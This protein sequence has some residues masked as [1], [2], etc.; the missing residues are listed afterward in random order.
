ME[1]KLWLFTKSP[2]ILILSFFQ[3]H[4]T[5]KTQ[6][7]Q[8]HAVAPEII[9]CNVS[10]Y[11]RLEVL[12]SS[13]SRSNWMMASSSSCSSS[14]NFASYGLFGSDSLSLVSN[15][16]CRWSMASNSTVNGLLYIFFIFNLWLEAWG[17][18]PML[19]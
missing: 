2:H 14:R 4:H 13:M 5:N 6:Q 18:S 15:A 1:K 16:N 17:F 8:R 3:K 19:N 11:Q 7:E 9:Y 10:I 12:P